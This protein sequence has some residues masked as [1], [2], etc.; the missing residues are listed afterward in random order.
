MTMAAE[1]LEPTAG[2]TEG[3]VIRQRQIRYVAMAVV[4]AVLQPSQPEVP[5][6]D[7][8][9][10]VVL[11][12]QAAEAIGK[13]PE[14]RENFKRIMSTGEIAV[15]LLP[16]N[17]DAVP[18]CIEGTYDGYTLHTDDSGEQMARLEPTGDLAT[19]QERAA[20]LYHFQVITRDPAIPEATWDQVING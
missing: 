11:G 9:V 10:E 7:S 2:T 12:P 20:L 14:L 17:A 19:P 4:P 5:P 6:A 1:R 3:A 15:R 16:L 18:K 8:Q 13:D